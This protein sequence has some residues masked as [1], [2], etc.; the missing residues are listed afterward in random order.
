VI[1]LLLVLLLSP[2]EKTAEKCV[3]SGTV[4]NAVTGEPLTKVRILAEGNNDDSGATPATTS[5]A[6]G[7]FTLIDINPGRYKLRGRRNGFLDG[8]Y[9]ARRPEGNGT[10]VMAEPGQQITNLVLK[11]TPA[12]VIA[13]TVRDADGEPLSRITVTVHRIKYAD[14]RRRIVRVG[15]AYADD[16]G[17][18]RIP[19]LPPGKYY[20]Y[21][22]S[23]K[24]R[25]FGQEGDPV[26]ADHSAKD[27]PHALTL[28]PSRYPSMQ[29]VGPGSRVTG[30][31]IVMPRSATV[32][33]KG[34]VTPPPGMRVNNITL[35][36][37]ESETDELGLRLVTGAD[38]KGEFE[39]REVPPG[40]Y[41][42]VAS[43]VPPTK[44]FNGTFE[45]FPE[46]LK[47]RVPL[48]VG[49]TEVKG[50][51]I[52]IAAGAEISGRIVVDGD[53]KSKLGGNLIEFDDGRSDPISAFVL[54]DNTFK[55]ALAP[56]QYQ[57]N[58]DGWADD[59]VVRSMR[60]GGRDILT[61]GLVVSEPGKVAIEIVLAHDG[62]KV[63][64]TV[65][66]ADEKAVPGAT[67]LLVPENRLRARTDLFHQGES[68]QYGRFSFTGI[69]PGEYKAFAWDDVEPGIWWD[70]EF[71][72]KYESQG[73]TVKV[74][75]K[76]KLTTN[77]HLA[78]E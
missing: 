13:G 57:V 48:Q 19:D 64:G 44:P 5:D 34:S 50:I 33:V 51:H 49:T 18:Y 2:Q 75:A 53:D 73:E 54:D 11:L 39:F 6:K 69:T 65:L 76:G 59:L 61:E 35:Q 31:D 29:E 7:Q 25:E 32:A 24:A 12:G 60:A 63:E 15:G 30:V 67:I 8:Y 45:M 47:T 43:T 26:T 22:D 62:G 37:S 23:K 1:L 20:V 3:L 27:A 10:P 9:G 42:L 41:T 77:V 17:Q 16:L 4:I 52:V 56:G 70:P 58:A 14:G 46:N 74:D 68:D 72:K 78:K 55:S 36:E 21:A 71:L 38:D 28:L 40:N 66:S